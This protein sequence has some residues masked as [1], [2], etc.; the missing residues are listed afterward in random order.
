MA[1]TRSPQPLAQAQPSSPPAPLYETT[2][3]HNLPLPGARGLDCVVFGK[4]LGGEG[5]R[6]SSG[7]I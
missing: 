5:I 1:S 6:Q 7:F 4:V 3:K 2:T